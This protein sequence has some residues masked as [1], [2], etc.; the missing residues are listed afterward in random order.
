M[1]AS[2]LWAIVAGA[3]TLALAAFFTVLLLVK[4]LWAWTIPDLFPGAVRQG[5]VAGSISWLTAMKVA[6]FV[7]ILSGFS[8]GQ[9]GLRTGSA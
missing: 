5:L 9:D 1:C 8:R 7:A 4:T 2:R 6:L 3:A